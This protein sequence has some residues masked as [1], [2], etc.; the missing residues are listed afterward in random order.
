MNEKQ[1]WESY[2]VGIK[3]R[4]LYQQKCWEPRGPPRPLLVIGD[5]SSGHEKADH[6]F[7]KDVKVRVGPQGQF[8]QS[9]LEALQHSPSE[10][11]LG[12]FNTQDT[13]HVDTT[14]QVCR[15]RLVRTRRRWPL[16]PST[17]RG[18]ANT[19]APFVT[20]QNRHIGDTGTIWSLI[21][22]SWSKIRPNLA[23]CGTDLATAGALHV[24]GSNH[25]FPLFW[26]MKRSFFCD[27]AQTSFAS[28]NETKA[29]RQHQLVNRNQQEHA[30]KWSKSSPKWGGW[31]QSTAW[32]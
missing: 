18:S 13:K 31:W 2:K 28:Q 15:L 19:S 24:R 17:L 32:I 11:C 10:L 20:C 5:C 4:T 22:V 14:Q 21:I 8:F 9:D 23:V 6:T 30:K 1:S 16:V 27:F 7:P 3:L 12:P 25:N 29:C 26:H